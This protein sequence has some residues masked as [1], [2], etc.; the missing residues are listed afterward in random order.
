[1]LQIQSSWFPLVDRN[2][3]VFIDIP[4]ADESDYRKA[5]NTVFRSRLHPSHLELPVVNAGP[6]E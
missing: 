2:P 5:T 1:M 3:Q 6:D 4:N